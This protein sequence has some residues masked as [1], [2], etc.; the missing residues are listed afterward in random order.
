MEATSK[1]VYL[2]FTWDQETVLPSLTL[3]YIGLTNSQP[4]TL[5]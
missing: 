3:L 2:W 1:Y 4:A 5:I